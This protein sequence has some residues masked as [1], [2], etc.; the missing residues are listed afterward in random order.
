VLY[1]ISSLN[2]MEKLK[3]EWH[4]VFNCCS[5][6]TAFQSWEW[7]YGAAKHHYPEELL[8]IIVSRNAEGKIMGIAPLSLRKY[9]FPGI[10]ILEFIGTRYS[11]YLDII[12]NDGYKDFF[13]EELVKWI[14][15][16]KEWQIINFISLRKET[17]EM[18]SKYFSFE[19]SY[20]SVCPYV[21]LPASFNDYKKLLSNSFLKKIRRN[22]KNIQSK[23]NLI[24][25]ISDS[26]QDFH[27][28][29]NAFFELHQKR[30]NKKGQRGH[31]REERWREQFQSISTLLYLSGMLR[32]GSLKI[33]SEVISIQFNLLLKNKEYSY[34]SG[35][36]PI[37]EQYS[38]GKLLD[39]YMIEDAIKK[40]ITEYDFLQGSEPYK[41]KWTKKDVQLYKVFFS[42]SI[43]LTFFWKKLQKIKYIVYN[44]T[45]I[46]KV[47]LFIF[48]NLRIF[49][50]VLKNIK[51]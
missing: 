51:N 42:R 19:Y 48:E 4:E 32:I 47:Y 31:F 12:A 40:G 11:D 20:H 41:Y 6:C 5:S 36:E 3:V 44:S 35:F 46:K 50:S 24:F 21:S 33:N 10:K 23:G 18:L 9:G 2:E 15:K 22:I 1:L 29:L 45:T 39:Y 43:L 26:I 16:N 14:R 8:R 30:Q 27:E 34:L 25:S 38:P 49:K 17:I 28:D 13:A 7:N 37:Y